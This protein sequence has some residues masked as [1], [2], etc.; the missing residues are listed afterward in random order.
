[1]VVTNTFAFN[2]ILYLISFVELSFL[3]Y[4]YVNQCCDYN[5]LR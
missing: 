1:M 5:Y 2:I 3:K 4:T